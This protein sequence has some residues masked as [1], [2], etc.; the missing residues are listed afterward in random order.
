MSG[1]KIHEEGIIDCLLERKFDQ[2]AP[3][4]ICNLVKIVAS[5]SWDKI[6]TIYNRQGLGGIVIQNETLEM[7]GN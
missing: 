3:Q 2:I 5:N 4:M 7:H 6:K 1:K